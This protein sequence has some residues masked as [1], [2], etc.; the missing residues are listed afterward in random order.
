M[1]LFF[2]NLTILTLV[3][4]AVLGLFLK[5]KK[6]G[7][8]CCGLFGYCGSEP[9]SLDKIKILGLFNQERGTDS[10]GLTLNDVTTK[11]F[12]ETAKF[13]KFIQ[14]YDFEN[15][16]DNFTV[17][18]HTRRATHGLKNE[19]NAHPFEVFNTPNDTDPILVLAHNGVIRN[20]QDLCKE[21]GVDTK[22]IFVDSLGLANIIAKKKE[23]IK[24]L[25]EYKGGAALLFYPVAKK[26]CL[27]I[28]H[29]MSKAY[30]HSKAEEER[31]L[32]Y[33]KVKDKDQVYVSSLKEA[34]YAIG[35]GGKGN[36]VFQV[37]HNKLILI[38]DGKF[39]KLKP[40]L[41]DMNR[42][43][44]VNEV[45]ISTSN[46][47]THNDH[48][49]GRL[50]SK[51]SGGGQTGKR[52]NFPSKETKQ[53]TEKEA[54][55]EWV[56]WR[57]NGASG[58]LMA[59]NIG[60]D[61]EPIEKI[62]NQKLHGNKIYFWRGRYWRNGH[63][64]G[65][66]NLGLVVTL[67]DEG[68]EEG[69]PGYI[70]ATKKTYFFINGLLC[71]DE[72]A[73]NTLYAEYNKKENSLCYKFYNDSGKQKWKPNTEYLS[74]YIRGFV[75]TIGNSYGDAYCCGVM[76]D[77]TIIPKFSNKSYT[78]NR[79]DFE[80]WT[81]LSEIK[82]Q[83]IKNGGIITATPEEVIKFDS[84]T[85]PFMPDMNSYGRDS[86]S[87]DIEDEMKEVIKQNEDD[88]KNSVKDGAWA[89]GVP[90]NPANQSTEE[91]KE[92]ENLDLFIDGMQNLE[93]NAKL[94]EQGLTDADKGSNSFKMVTKLKSAYNFLH[95]WFTIRYEEDDEDAIEG[96]T[97]VNQAIENNNKEQKVKVPLY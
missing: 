77:G 54:E 68:V 96:E 41:S 49:F 72:A 37:E 75:H 29:G 43:E 76:I 24:V 84:G 34:L 23:N 74:K 58:V 18:G 26:N 56:L 9:P 86:C 25:R 12:N 48:N 2:A 28:F 55:T 17:I 69:K 70:I 85:L 64:A 52:S 67:D 32:F 44:M 10:C 30:T 42:S 6:I 4:N 82:A 47:Y 22:D 83:F 73:Y 91:A 90:E 88:K 7:M 36:E 19:T 31:P 87:K 80:K 21:Y 8:L 53:K 46:W 81:Y 65:G 62:Y 51:A 57:D 3:V 35:G 20:W 97:L 78:F 45:T 71:N 95:E 89:P 13:E 63:I 92:E 59:R 93:E 33:W 11:G 5:P 1:E 79:G 61:T 94:I 60:I 16:T 27:Y 50:A 66:N 40:V 14:T 38:Q 39:V 15:P